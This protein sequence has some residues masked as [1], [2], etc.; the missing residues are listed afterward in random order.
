MVAAT[1]R[2][3]HRSDDRRQ[4]EAGEGARQSA[5]PDLTER[6]DTEIAVARL[7]RWLD[8]MRAADGYGG[9]VAHWWQQCFLYTGAGL[10][11]RYEGII[12]GYLELWKRTRNEQWL[13]KARRAGDDLVTGQ[14]TTGN[15]RYS[16]F[17]MNPASGGTPHEAACAYALLLFAKTLL[18]EG[19][20]DWSRYADCAEANLRSFYIDRRWDS[21]TCSFLDG[22]GDG[23]FVPNKAATI[24][25]ALFL[26]ATVRND[27]SLATAYALPALD[28]VID[29]QVRDTGPLDGAIAQNSF[30]NRRIEKYFPIYIARCVPALIDAYH[31]T[32]NPHYVD[33]AL[34]AMRFVWR[35][36]DGDG[37]IPTVVYTN[38]KAS[39][40]PAW[41]APLG[42]VLRAADLV[43]PFGFDGSS[44]AIAGRL[45]AGQGCSGGVQ[46]ATGFAGQA[47]RTRHA[48]PDVR[49]ILHV[50]GWCDKA[51]RYLSEHVTRD[52]PKVSTGEFETACTFRGSQLTFVETPEL[53]EISAG[54]DVRYRWRKGQPWAEI[55]RQEFWL[56]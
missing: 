6:T 42:D 29:H 17:E 10:D 8:T 19:L 15:F 25:Q 27:E 5:T 38:G 9:P 39:R 50:A 40:H 46:T 32:D 30:G 54:K 14:T 55:A 12:A 37:V 49:D 28:R 35:W 2:L 13:A 4:P 48:Q 21:T 20:P 41:I 22:P 16:A 44:D 36:A 7:D 26:L 33:A 3:H 1:Q 18:S 56:R 53:V 43:R 45:L 11:W 34:R 51:F 23:S 31:W 52:L 24:C 47:G